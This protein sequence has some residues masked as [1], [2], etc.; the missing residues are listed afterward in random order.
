MERTTGYGAV[1]RA[2]VGFHRR[3]LIETL[4]VRGARSEDCSL[5]FVTLPLPLALS[6]SDL[7]LYDYFSLLGYDYW[8]GK[9]IVLLSPYVCGSVPS[10]SAA[11]RL[12]V[13]KQVSR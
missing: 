2:S 13:S 9:P 7:Y 12:Q 4:R 3:G 1:F 5:G 6:A 8:L 10:S 11:L